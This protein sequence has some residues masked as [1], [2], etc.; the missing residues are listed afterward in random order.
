M[1]QANQSQDS[2]DD[3]FVVYGCLASAFARDLITNKQYKFFC[4]Q[5]SSFFQEWL[6]TS[7][8][9]RRLQPPTRTSGLAPSS[10]SV[11]FYGDWH[12]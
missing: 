4:L 1:E 9:K 10:S 12:L 5:T 2:A 8:S 3:V 6:E 11:E 7:I